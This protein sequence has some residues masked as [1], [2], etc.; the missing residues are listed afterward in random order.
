MSSGTAGDCGSF[1]HVLS[2]LLLLLSGQNCCCVRVKKIILEEF[3]FCKQIYNNG[4]FGA[5][6]Y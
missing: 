3:K 5:L 4:R 1:T 6:N 2:R